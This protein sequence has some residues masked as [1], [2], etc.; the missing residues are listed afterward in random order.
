[1]KFLNS[2]FLILLFCCSIVDAQETTGVL[3][4]VITDSTKEP[5]PF[6][7]VIVIDL[8]TNFKFGV[9]SKDKGFYSFTN[10]SPS[11]RYQMEI[12]FLGFKTN[13]VFNVTVNLGATTVKDFVMVE[14][15]TA[16]NEVVITTSGKKIE[17]GNEVVLNRKK[18]Q[19]YTN[20]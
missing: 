9:V 7:T 4:G 13:T 5:I 8:E 1:M 16:L 19:F 2:V 3:Q 18:N 20:H 14:E 12:S 10:L 6:A 15:K 11:D 17:S